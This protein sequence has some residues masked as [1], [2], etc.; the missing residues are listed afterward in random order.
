MGFRVLDRFVRTD[1]LN[2]VDRIHSPILEDPQFDGESN[3]EEFI[4]K[5]M[6]TVNTPPS[7]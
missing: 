2:A 3:V 1:G 4:S 5:L 6:S 7:I